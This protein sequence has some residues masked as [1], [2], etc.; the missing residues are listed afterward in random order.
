YCHVEMSCAWGQQMCQPDGTWTEC[1]VVPAPGTCKDEPTS[2]QDGMG[3]W[4]YDFCC[5]VEQGFCCQ[6]AYDGLYKAGLNPETGGK[7]DPSVQTNWPPKTT[8]PG[9]GDCVPG[10]QRWCWYHHGQQ[11]DSWGTSTCQAD[12][13]W[14]ACALSKPP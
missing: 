12:G 5:C 3:H 1:K 14:T 8:C 4:T 13:T 2:L 9:K 11:D 10:K 7:C 6:D